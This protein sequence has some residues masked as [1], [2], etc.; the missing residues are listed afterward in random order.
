MCLWCCWKNLDD[1]DLM[2]FEI[3]RYEFT[4]GPMIQATLV[5]TT[6]NLLFILNDEDRLNQSSQLAN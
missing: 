6:L 4:L 2:E 3:S 5:I 1:L